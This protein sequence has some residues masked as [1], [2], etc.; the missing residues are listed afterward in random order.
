[1]A[2]EAYTSQLKQWHGDGMAAFRCRGSKGC[3]EWINKPVIPP[4]S[5]YANERLQI[6]LPASRPLDCACLCVGRR[7]AQSGVASILKPL[8]QCCAWR[9]T[10]F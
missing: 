1:M 3:G 10:T 4:G 9:S 6:I 7:L 2:A 8:Y 5:F